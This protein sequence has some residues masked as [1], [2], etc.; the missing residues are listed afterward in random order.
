MSWFYFFTERN[1]LSTYHI[2]EELLVAFICFCIARRARTL[3]AGNKS[4]I[5]SELSSR[6]KLVEAG[7][8]VLGMSSLIHALIHATNLDLN[9]LYQTLL[10]YCL[11][12]LTIIIAISAEKP[13]TKM[14][15]PF[16]YVPLL[17][18]LFP[19]VNHKFP[20]FGEF[21]PLVW[22]SVAYLA[23]LV[24]M[25]HVATFYR[26]REGR[27]LWTSIGFLLICLSAIFLF[28]PASIGSTMWMHGHLFRPL[29]F[30]V[31]LFS[32]NHAVLKS[33]G[34]SILYRVLSAFSL[35]AAVPLLIF[36]TV[37]FYE[38]I[39]PMDIA[40]RRLLVFLLMLTTFASALVFG[41]GMTLKLL[42]P[43]LYLRGAVDR[44]VDEGFKKE[45]KVT[46]NDEIGELSHA[47]NE[48]VVK[49]DHAVDEQERLGRLAATGELAATLAHEIKNP[50]NAIG[51]AASYIKKNY[52]GSLIDE[53]TGVIS[54]EVSRIN[55][56]TGTLLDFARPLKPEPVLCD[57]NKLIQDTV[58]LLG[59]EAK[60][61]GISLAAN[62]AGN[63]SPVL[64]DPN[65]MKQVLI[66]LLINAFAA[67]TANGQVSISSFRAEEGVMIAVEDNGTGIS[68]D[69]IN[70][71]F[72]PFFTTKTRGTG[73]GL[74]VSKKIA[75]D[76]QGDLV[77]KS[78]VGRGSSFTLILPE[79]R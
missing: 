5:G 33:M 75:R 54:D 10:G 51:G 76:H 70:H 21:R 26:V 23:G 48:M 49:L 73:L 22:I 25:L 18:L 61:Q 78:V 16:L 4:E 56:L 41:F 24:C 64:C 50:L 53:F 17:V 29:G 6:I 36:G 38:N 52:E 13:Q 68:P 60:D 65:Q 34:G 46:S 20:L 42:G 71:V 35:L 9:L 63:L 77:V 39:N 1:F 31:L 32:M 30:L 59:E 67:V 12:F 28:F 37:L 14:F 7:F 57:I 3:C 72:N 8:I 19:E 43:I 45:I 74:A 62:P 69:H 44:L 11:G 58:S 66:N 40:E 27:I 15:F 2:L 79:D 47:F 55:K